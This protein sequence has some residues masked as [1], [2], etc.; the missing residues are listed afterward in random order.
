[1]FHKIWGML[2]RCSTTQTSKKK[3]EK[4]YVSIKI[5]RGKQDKQKNWCWQILGNF[6]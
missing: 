1:M 2:W 3:K 4:E 5:D 6:T